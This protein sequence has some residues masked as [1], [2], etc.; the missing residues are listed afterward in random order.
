MDRAE[1]GR[2]V[3]AQGDDRTEEPW[4]A[5]I[6]VAVVE[7]LKGFPD[8]ISS[9]FPRAQIQTPDRVGGQALHRPSDAL[10]PVICELAGTQGPLGRSAGDLSGAERGGAIG[11]ALWLRLEPVRQ[12]VSFDRQHLAAQLGA[13]RAVLRIP[14]RN[15]A[16]QPVSQPR[17]LNRAACRRRGIRCA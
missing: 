4:P 6:L 17:R 3:L 7:G 8:A 12:E 1:R 13:G 11:R 16:D 2:E 9:V 10:Q 5:D 14:A 15:Q